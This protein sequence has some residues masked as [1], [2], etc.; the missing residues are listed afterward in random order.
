MVKSGCPS[1]MLGVILC[2]TFLLSAGGCNEKAKKTDD[3]MVNDFVEEF[4]KFARSGDA[5]HLVND[6][7]VFN[8][9]D[10]KWIVEHS[11]TTQPAGDLGNEKSRRE[12]ASKDV[13]L[14]LNS[15]SDLFGCKPKAWSSR[16]ANG[17]PIR[18]LIIWVEKGGKY[19]GIKIDELMVVRDRLKAVVW[20]EI[21]GYEAYNNV[22]A[23]RAILEVDDP[24]KCKFPDG[25]YIEYKTTL[26][27]G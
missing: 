12:D 21:S 15:Y 4:L 20:V 19:Y 14:F 26:H 18:S 23:K 2:S 13:K 27:P 25:E 16:G 10:A 24:S 6:L 5:D 22:K 17:L 11:A 1:S 3:E 7:T 8:D 9:A